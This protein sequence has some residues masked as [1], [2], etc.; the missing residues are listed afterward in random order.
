M[1][2]LLERMA[3][4]GRNSPQALD[5]RMPRKYERMLVSYLTS[6]TRNQYVAHALVT[7]AGKQARQDGKYPLTIE[8]AIDR[9]QT[10][11]FDGMMYIIDRGL[12][13][14]KI[15]GGGALRGNYYKG[16]QKALPILFLKN[17]GI[18]SGSPAAIMYD[19][20]TRYVQLGHESLNGLDVSQKGFDVLADN[21]TL[22]LIRQ[23]GIRFL[24]YS[25]KAVQALRG[26]V[27][28]A[29]L[30]KEPIME[31]VKKSLGQVKMQEALDLRIGVVDFLTGRGTLISSDNG[32]VNMFMYDAVDQSS[33]F[34]IA[35]KP[36]RKPGIVAT[37]GGLNVLPIRTAAMESDLLYVTVLNMH[38]PE[39]KQLSGRSPMGTVRQAYRMHE[40]LQA[41][42]TRQA[43]Q[44]EMGVD[45]DKVEEDPHGRVLAATANLSKFSPFEWTENH[46]NLES[47][48][49]SKTNNKFGLLDPAR[50]SPLY[51]A[52]FFLESLRLA[53]LHGGRYRLVM[54]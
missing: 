45:P 36:V 48:G 4:D 39:I 7:V 16:E 43:L 50:N 11:H 49:R 21:M 52:G 51:D 46:R 41:D 29:F 12:V 19:G 38:I 30:V 42:A 8:E 26:I 35:L 3:M 28:E 15:S 47:I 18:S 6:G 2:N 53:K 17:F 14:S 9:I 1:A 34:P 23:G 31:A 32:H 13:T 37:D 5:W 10:Y 54:N 33:S 40:I 25:R 27:G 20:R 24:P 44:Q 22:A